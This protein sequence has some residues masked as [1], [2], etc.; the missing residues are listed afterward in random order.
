MIV[1]TLLHEKLI[2]TDAVAVFKTSVVEAV[3][4]IFGLILKVIGAV[5]NEVSTVL[6]Y[7][8]FESLFTS[9]TASPPV[10]FVSSKVS[11]STILH[12]AFAPVAVLNNAFI[13]VNV[14]DLTSKFAFELSSFFA[15]VSSLRATLAV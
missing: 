8:E 6:T 13:S 10:L 9:S 3:V 12:A 2:F 5:P 7:S 14:I 4:V 1:V 11:Q 15:I